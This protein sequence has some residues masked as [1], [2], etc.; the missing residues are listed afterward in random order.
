MTDRKDDGLFELLNEAQQLA[1]DIL[2]FVQDR[3][4]NGQLGTTD[5]QTMVIKAALAIGYATLSKATSTSLHD[6]IELVM[7]IYKNTV[8]EK[9]E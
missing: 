7:T 8:V 5:H 2:D 4:A 3:V 1:S 6:T 9:E